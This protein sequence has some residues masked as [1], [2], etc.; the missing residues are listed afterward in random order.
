MEHTIDPLIPSK[1]SCWMR[2]NMVVWRGKLLLIIRSFSQHTYRI[3]ECKPHSVEVF[4]L[5][6]SIRPCGFTQIHNFDGDCIFVQ[7][8]CCR[9]FSAGLHHASTIVFHMYTAWEMVQW[10]VLLPV[11]KRAALVSSFG[12][13]LLLELE[14][15]FYIFQFSCAVIMCWRAF[16]YIDWCVLCFKLPIRRWRLR[17]I[18]IGGDFQF[19]S[20][21]LIC[22]KHSRWKTLMWHVTC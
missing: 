15:P 22:L 10:G 2:C 9:P 11:Y 5:D 14:V 16:L 4:A 1:P 3:M 13:F 21:T 8:S 18:A 7:K 12:F 19:W 6:F 20:A 17:G